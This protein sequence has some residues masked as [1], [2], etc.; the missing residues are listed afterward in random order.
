MNKNDLM[1][2]VRI[3]V[4]DMRRATKNLRAVT[5]IEDREIVKTTM[6]LEEIAVRLR[7]LQALSFSEDTQIVGRDMELAD[8]LICRENTREELEKVFK[9]YC[10]VAEYLLGTIGKITESK[11]SAEERLN[12]LGNRISALKRE[13]AMLEKIISS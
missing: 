1:N 12:S 9:L 8:Y 5:D 7:N 3:L 2:G 11:K 6:F 10:I 13:R 4:E